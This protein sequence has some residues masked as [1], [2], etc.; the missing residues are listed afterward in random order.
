M[1]L[2]IFIVLIIGILGGLLDRKV[3]RMVEEGNAANGYRLGVIG[4][5]I[6]I[7]VLVG[8]LINTLFILA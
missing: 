5:F 6:L 8:L 4:N 7:V 2:N 1:I 3:N